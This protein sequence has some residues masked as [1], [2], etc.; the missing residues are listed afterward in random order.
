MPDKSQ[1]ILIV[2]DEVQLL[3]S[4][5][6]KITHE[7][8]TALEAKNGVEGLKIALREKPDV[9]L[10][11]IIM[12]KMDGIEMLDKLRR[13]KWGQTTI[14]IVLSNDDD[15]SHISETLKD[16]ASDYLIKSDWSLEDIITKIKEALLAKS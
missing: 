2:E 6:E 8:F 9:I 12:P 10:L 4:L 1:K 7:G 5:S 16:N 15:P 11:D 13:D 14:V 3:K